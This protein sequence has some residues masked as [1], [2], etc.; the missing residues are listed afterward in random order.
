MKSLLTITFTVVSL[1]SIAQATLFLDYFESGSGNWT[2]AGD[3]TPNFWL[4]NSCAGNGTTTAGSNSM[5]ISPGG[6]IPGCGVTGTEQYAYTDAPGGSVNEAISYTTIDGT[7]A[8][9]LIADFDYRIQGN[10][11]AD[12]AELVYSIDG[13]TSW[14]AVGSELAQSA[15]WTTTSI[16]LPALLDGTTFL[17]GFRFTYDDATVTGQPIAIDNLFVSGTDTVDPIVVCPNDTLVY[18]DEFCDGLIKDWIMES[19]ISDNCSP[20]ANLNITQSPIQGTVVPG[21]NVITTITITVEDEA[22][23]TAQCT[24]DATTVDTL[25]P[26]ISCPTPTDLFVDNNCE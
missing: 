5:Y 6:S 3:V 11:G 20:Y 12:Y 23:N 17:L 9:S 10:S 26:T 19:T 21:T 14:V 8:T 7:C 16:A 2:F 24:M 13:G 4:V 15:A 18:V 22:G 25:D 1:F